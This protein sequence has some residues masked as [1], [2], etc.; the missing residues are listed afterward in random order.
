MWFQCR[1]SAH[2]HKFL[3]HLQKFNV[4]TGVGIL[5]LLAVVLLYVK[6]KKKKKKKK[7]GKEKRF[8]AVLVL[9]AV[10]VRFGIGIIN[11]TEYFCMGYK[12]WCT[13]DYHEG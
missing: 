8:C 6:K 9:I 12:N 2:W 3:L 11:C 1:I 4:G 7:T 13:F 5:Y 10:P